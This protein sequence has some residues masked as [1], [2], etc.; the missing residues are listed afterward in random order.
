MTATAPSERWLDHAPGL[1]G[2]PR[3]DGRPAGAELASWRKRPA[4]Q[5]P[6][7]PDPG[8]LAAVTAQLRQLPP[9]VFAGECDQLTERLAAVARG[10]AFLLQGGD[11]AGTIARLT[12]P[13]ARDK[14]PTQ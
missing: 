3:E 9:L 11:C 8:R 13:A 14:R 10:E 1:G 7:W 6:D 12:A 4:A 2:P 5:Q